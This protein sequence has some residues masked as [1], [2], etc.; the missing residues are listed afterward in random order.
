[1][2][3]SD[4]VFIFEPFLY[5]QFVYRSPPPPIRNPGSAPD[6]HVNAYHSLF[7]NTQELF[8]TDRWTD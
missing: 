1:M 2:E 4:F 8:T 3:N 6:L 7:L 5:P